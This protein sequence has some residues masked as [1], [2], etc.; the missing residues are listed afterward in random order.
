MQLGASRST[1]PASAK[2]TKAAATAGGQGGASRK[3][4]KGKHKGQL[5]LPAALLGSLAPTEGWGRLIFL[6]WRGKVGGTSE[7]TRC[8]Q[9]PTQLAHRPHLARGVPGLACG[10]GAGPAVGQKVKSSPAVAQEPLSSLRTLTSILTQD[11]L[12]RGA[13]C[14]PGNLA[15]TW[16]ASQPSCGLLD[17]GPRS[18][19][20]TLTPVCSLLLSF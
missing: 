14:L 20:W 3:E 9:G 11:S 4:K 16:A 6:T 12:S 8:T 17:S 19:L 7:G 18:T 2:R 1:A 5:A 10:C 13:P 15:H